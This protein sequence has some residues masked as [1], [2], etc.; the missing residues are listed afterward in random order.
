MCVI[1][2]CLCKCCYFTPILFPVWMWL[3]GCM[4]EK[5]E[6]KTF[7]FCTGKN[8]YI[9]TVGTI[10]KKVWIYFPLP[11]GNTGVK[12]FKVVNLP[13]K[14]FFMGSLW[15]ILK[16]NRCKDMDKSVLLSMV[17]AR[18][19]LEHGCCYHSHW[20]FFKPLPTKQPP[21]LNE[22]KLRWEGM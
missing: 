15:C 2:P 1:P 14:F 6:Q 11:W 8:V 20:M 13:G 18:G 17:R 19:R 3:V 9:D 12:Y 21:N 10:M 5:K 4:H 22:C 7:S 16:G